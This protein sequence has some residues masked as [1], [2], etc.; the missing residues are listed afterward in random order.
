MSRLLILALLVLLPARQIFAQD[1]GSFLFDPGEW[2]S[3]EGSSLLIFTGSD[4]CHNCMRLEQTV[5]SDTT[6]QSAAQP[7]VQM[8]LIDLPRS[9]KN[10]SEEAQRAAKIELAERYNPEGRFPFL[11]LLDPA[12]EVISSTGF[13]SEISQD[14]LNWI[15]SALQQP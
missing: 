2:E 1:D 7:L 9:K 15:Q 10:Q 5:L 11:V 8:L 12:K 4:W 13:I 6:F 14:Y 3:T